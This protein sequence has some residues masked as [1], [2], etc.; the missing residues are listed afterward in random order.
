MTVSELINYV[1][2]PNSS[3]TY[4]VSRLVN[5]E[6]IKEVNNPKDQR[7]KILTLTDLGRAIFIKTYEKT[8]S[9]HAGTI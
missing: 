9:T 3:M 1:L 5:K 2:I 8:L 4:V 7:V 6:Y